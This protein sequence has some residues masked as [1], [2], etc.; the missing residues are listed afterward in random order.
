[1]KRSS[2]KA[3]RGEAPPRELVAGAAGRL[4]VALAAA[5]QL[6]I[7]RS[8]AKALIVEGRVAV[9][10]QACDDPSRR[11]AAGDKVSVRIPPPADPRPAP[12][13]IPLHVLHEDEEVIVIDKPAGLVAHPAPGNRTGTLVNALIAHCGDSLAGIGGVRRPGIVHRL[14][15]NTSG[16]MVVAKTERAQAG[17]AAQ[18]A[19][20][21]RNGPLERRYLALVWGVPARASGVIEAPLGRSTANRLK[22]AVVRETAPDARHAVT[23]YRIVRAFGDAAALVECRLETGRTHQIRVHMAHIGHPLVGDAEYGSGFATKA[24]RLAEPAR[25]E[26][27][28]FSRQALHAA[29]LVFAHPATGAAMRF[30]TPVPA[31]FS[32]LLQAFATI[33]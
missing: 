12:E 4:D 24:N 11:L 10:G 20:H 1:M 26:A 15:R 14:D 13:A 6:A 25:S 16:V 2:R 27:K 22:R 18:F 23:R 3:G 5:A 17:L 7:S 33:G 21:G 9:N 32:Q 8:R 29:V 31:D 28:S 19:D 30:E